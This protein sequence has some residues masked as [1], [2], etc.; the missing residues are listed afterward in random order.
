MA[1]SKSATLATLPV[2]TTTSSFQQTAAARRWLAA[3]LVL[4]LVSQTLGWMHRAL[5]GAGRQVPGSAVV[6]LINSPAGHSAS[7]EAEAL[8]GWVKALFGSHD[9]AAQCQLFDAATHTGITQVPDITP[10]LAP[11]AQS[12]ARTESAFVARWAAL[13]DARG[14]PVFRS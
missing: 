8:H 3:L 2:M 1:V 10:G 13:F 11:T 4:L 9:D 6:S 7:G 12:L 5:H 14:P